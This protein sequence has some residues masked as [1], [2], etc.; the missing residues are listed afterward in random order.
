[1][2]AASQFPPRNV[3]DE[4]RPNFGRLVN[5]CFQ[6]RSNELEAWTK[7]SEWED[8]EARLDRWINDLEAKS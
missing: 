2:A 5:V 7:F 4:R 1:M 8:V 6:V 3:L